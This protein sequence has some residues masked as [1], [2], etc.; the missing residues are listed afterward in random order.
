MT[1]EEAK[2]VL[3]LYRPKIDQGDPQFADALV[4][5]ERDPDL[6]AWLRE[7]CAVDDALRGKLREAPVPDDLLEKTL[8]Y[9]PSIWW[10]ESWLRV[11]ACFLVLGSL[12]FFW[13]SREP[14]RGT[15][16]TYQRTMARVVSNYRMSLETND[17]E[18]VRTF[19]ANNQ[20]P[21]DYTLP[22]SITRQHLLGCATLSWDGNPVSLL[23][24]RH[25][26]GA[27]LWLFVTHRSELKGGP[28]SSDPVF[29]QANQI[30][31]ASWRQNGNLY[32][33]ASRGDPKLLR[34]SVQ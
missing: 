28:R 11:A 34:E 21:A 1:R 27:E 7:R 23:C 18:R 30:N 19:L 13:F 20:A 4:E 8:R 5:A 3:A 2:K 15:F 32:L 24:F 14:R 31:T 17:L 25:E 6:A 12:A 10:K 29:G 9:R 16:E 22:P 26:S 33:L